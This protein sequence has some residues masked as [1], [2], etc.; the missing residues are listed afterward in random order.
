MNSSRSIFAIWVV[1]VSGIIAVAGNMFFFGNPPGI[2][3]FIFTLLV[4]TAVIG[5]AFY[6]DRPIT[7]RNMWLVV[8]SLFFSAMVAVRADDYQIMVNIIATGISLSWFLYYISHA[9]AADTASSFSHFLAL[10][11][12]GTRSVLIDPVVNTKEAV[13]WARQQ[14]KDWFYK[15][16][17]GLA[18]ALPVMAVLSGILSV[19]NPVFRSYMGNVGSAFTVHFAELL[20]R[21]GFTLAIMWV[22]GGAMTYTL[23]RNWRTLSDTEQADDGDTTPKSKWERISVFLF[24]QIVFTVTLV[25]LFRPFVN[26]QFSEWGYA[27]GNSGSLF[28]LIV[29]AGVVGLIVATIVDR[30]WQKQQEISDDA[31]RGIYQKDSS[32]KNDDKPTRFSWLKM[33]IIESGIVLVGVNLLYVTFIL[34]EFVYLFGDRGQYSVSEYARRG[35]A[36]LLII[37][38]LTILI[39]LIIE[40][41]TTLNSPFQVMILRGLSALMIVF[42]IVILLSS[43]RRIGLYIDA[44]GYTQMRVWG[45]MFMPW[46]AVI[47]VGLLMSIFQVR[48]NVFGL[49]LMVTAM[50]Y[51]ASIAL[52]DVDGF[53]AARNVNRYLQ[54]DK[55]ID[56][57]YLNRLDVEA[58]PSIIQLM[59][60]TEDADQLMWMENY[61]V[62]RRDMLTWYDDHGFMSFHFARHNALQNLNAM[63]LPDYQLSEGQCG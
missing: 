53:V 6:L 40:R 30:T 13:I 37:S 62:D 23:A 4:L 32:K 46:M 27:T 29:V 8:P 20:A 35:F 1:F 19:A 59:E 54:D 50:G 7:L 26:R 24:V 48:R 18:F 22:L 45:M 15:T 49:V 39:L 47:F 57:C 36:E 17:R 31:E 41:V 58:I 56:L 28:L 25:Y 3:V 5:T 42:G 43:M 38:V 12:T 44:L 61:L 14:E 2:S 51:L 10:I 9:H 55:P 33:G 21:T 11:E 60:N 34:T 63:E 52:I 16:L